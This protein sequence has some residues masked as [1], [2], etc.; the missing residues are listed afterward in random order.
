MLKK[1]GRGGI[2]SDFLFNCILYGIAIV[3][4]VICLYPMYFVVIASVSTPSAV[5]GG[6][7]ILL[8]KGLN[9]KGYQELFRYQRIWKSYRNTILYTLSGTLI[10]LVVNLLAGYALSRKE[11]VGKRFIMVLFMI[12]MFFSGGLIPTYMLISGLKLLDTVWVMMIPGA[13]VTYFIIIARTFF[14]NSLPEELWEAAQLDGCSFRYYFIKV[15][16]P[17]SKAVIAVLALWSAVGQ[18]NSYF[19]ALVYLRNPDL[20]P[21][22]IVLRNILINN[23]ELTEMMVGTSTAEEALRMTEL[24]KYCIIVV[25][26]APILCLYPFLQKYF[27]QGVMIGS[28]KG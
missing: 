20:Q 19:N 16:L 23:Q 17:L 9:L 27:N 6:D 21:L 13:V 28:V 24:L 10:T 4:F 3:L 5:A 15:A 2:R 11:L 12:P 7:V 14:Q 26:S 25:S 8:P 18:W 22:Q 1:H